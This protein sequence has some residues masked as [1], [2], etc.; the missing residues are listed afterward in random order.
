MSDDLYM[1]QLY[2]QLGGERRHKET[3]AVKAEVGA[4]DCFMVAGRIGTVRQNICYKH[5]RSSAL[6]IILDHVVYPLPHML[7]FEYS[8]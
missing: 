3:F 2:A 5:I 8:P 4:G 1:V 6:G 7:S